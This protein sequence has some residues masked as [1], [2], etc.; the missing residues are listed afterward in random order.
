MSSK[1]DAIL[2]NYLKS[3]KLKEKTT[4]SDL[5]LTSVDFSERSSDPLV[6]V[7]KKLILSYCKHESQLTTL[8]NINATITNYASSAID[9]KASKE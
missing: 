3:A 2:Q 8:R 6:E 4:L 1:R 7:V 5:E 9:N